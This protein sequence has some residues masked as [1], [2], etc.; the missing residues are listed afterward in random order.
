MKEKRSS[1]GHRRGGAPSPSV[2]PLALPPVTGPTSIYIMINIIYN[3]DNY[4]IIIIIIIIGNGYLLRVEGT[5][6]R[7]PHMP[8]V[9]AVYASGGGT[10]CSRIQPHLPTRYYLPGT[11]PGTRRDTTLTAAYRCWPTRRQTTSPRPPSRGSFT[12]CIYVVSQAFIRLAF[13][14]LVLCY[15]IKF[16]TYCVR[17]GRASRRPRHRGSHP[18][19]LF[20]SCCHIAALT[21]YAS[22]QLTPP[23]PFRLSAAA[24]K[25]YCNHIFRLSPFPCCTPPL[26]GCC[27]RRPYAAECVV[28]VAAHLLFFYAA[29]APFSY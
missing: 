22:I 14:I 11:V 18:I 27:T 20:L 24:S 8:T 1:G 15:P 6:T 29:L 23:P 9:Y 3:Y 2:S 5:S 21:G 19:R 16:V 4:K 26:F 17:A 12:S 10:P 13:F 28:V 7:T 25:K